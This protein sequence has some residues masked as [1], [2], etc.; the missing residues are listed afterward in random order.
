MSVSTVNDEP[1]RVKLVGVDGR[2][3]R[4]A[5][6]ETLTEKIASGEC[7]KM[8]GRRNTYRMVPALKRPL[9]IPA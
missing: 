7:V 5:D 2:T 4:Y 3:F 8:A 9:R 6:L 1:K